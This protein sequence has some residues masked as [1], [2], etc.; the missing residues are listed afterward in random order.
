MVVG[1]A[2]AIHVALSGDGKGEI[3]T[4]EGILE[5]HV[6]PGSPGFQQHT[7]G[8]QESLCRHRKPELVTD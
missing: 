4:T 2:E 1:K 3:G 6:A 5:S 8:D 7:L